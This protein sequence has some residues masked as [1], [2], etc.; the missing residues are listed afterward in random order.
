MLREYFNVFSAAGP[1]CAVLELAIIDWRSALQVG[2]ELIAAVDLGSNSFRL[3]VGR[4]VGDQIYPLDAIKESVRLASGL[5]A[6]KRLDAASANARCRRCRASVSACAD[7]IR[8]RSGRS[9]PM[10]C[11]LPRMPSSFAGGRSCTGVSDR[12]HRR[13]EEA[14][15]IYL[16]AV[17]SLPAA[18]HKRLVVDIGGGSTEFIIGRRIEPQLMESLYMGCVSYTMRFSRTAA[19]TRSAC[20]RRRPPRRPKSE[21]RPRI[22]PP[23]L[24][25]GGR[26]VGFGAG[27]RRYPGDEQVQ[28][29]RPV[30]GLTASASSVCRRP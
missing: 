8:R 2:Y 14:R 4:V 28:S 12:N 10:P 24:A 18:Q 23:W 27:D 29:G 25:R 1:A 9:P 13:R 15:L 7:S 26:F 3:Q 30:A 16:G 21:H 20:V 5:T 22:P 6:D 19:S 17:H 11:A